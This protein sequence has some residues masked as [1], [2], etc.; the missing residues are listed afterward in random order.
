MLL[1]LP[2]PPLSSLSLYLLPFGIETSGWPGT[3]RT[4]RGAV[5]PAHLLHSPSVHQRAAR[6]YSLRCGCRSSHNVYIT[7]DDTQGELQFALD[8]L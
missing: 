7:M 1:P 3:A 6:E 2:P 5:L 8:V 4:S